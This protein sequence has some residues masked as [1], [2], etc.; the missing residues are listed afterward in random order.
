MFHN[1]LKKCPIPRVEL[2]QISKEQKKKKKSTTDS[3]PM[4]IIKDILKDPFC[5]RRPKC[6]TVK[7]CVS[8][9]ARVCVTELIETRYK[10]QSN[11]LINHL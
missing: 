7:L 9:R 8:V 2:K 3:V 5:G 6:P 4:I 1:H 11:S 10:T